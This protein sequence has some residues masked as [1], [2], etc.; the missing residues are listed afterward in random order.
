MEITGL[1]IIHYQGSACRK[2]CTV[3][4]AGLTWCCEFVITIYSGQP[5]LCETWGPA[6]EAD[7]YH[8]LNMTNR[9]PSLSVL[10]PALL[11][12]NAPDLSSE[13]QKNGGRYAFP[14]RQ[15]PRFWCSFCPVLPPPPTPFRVNHQVQSEVPSDFQP[16]KNGLSDPLLGVRWTF[17]QRIFHL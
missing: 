11:R 14:C 2:C 4:V 3:P 10:H 13:P 6:A 15:A 5:H 12:K 1:R 7:S 9:P 8:Q 16:G 17:G